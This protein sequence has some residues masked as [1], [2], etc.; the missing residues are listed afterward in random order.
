MTSTS[1]AR[2]AQVHAVDSFENLPGTSAAIA[3]RRAP[4]LFDYSTVQ[5]NKSDSLRKRV[6]RIKA[7]IRRGI[8]SAIEIG[9]ELTALKDELDHG[10]FGRWLQAEFSWTERTACNYMRVFEV[11]GTKPEI[12]S[13]LPQATIYRLAARSTPKNLVDDV[14]TQL[15]RGDQ[16]DVDRIEARIVAARQDRKIVQKGARRSPAWRAKQAKRRDAEEAA[17][18][19]RERKR[20]LEREETARAI[21][22][23]IIQ[24]DTAAT[25]LAQL[26]DDDRW[27]DVSNEFRRQVVARRQGA[28]E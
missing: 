23:W 12:V 8:G 17:R 21:S 10:Q 6:E 5:P 20:L 1:L 13:D 27:W 28:V 4:A 22:N 3:A 15:E 14:V 19:E 11:F 24:F 18:S 26:F 9:G 16:V 25:A 2:P 7:A